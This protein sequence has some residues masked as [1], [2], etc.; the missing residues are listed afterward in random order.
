MQFRPQAPRGSGGGAVGPVQR[1]QI[2][3]GALARLER[4]ALVRIG[5]LSQ[6]KRIAFK[7]D[8]RRIPVPA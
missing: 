5:E 7:L 2:S 6:I 8:N 1:Y 3:G 4:T